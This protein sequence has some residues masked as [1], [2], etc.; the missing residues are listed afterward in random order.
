MASR[1][2]TY[3]VYHIANWKG[4]TQLCATLLGESL[5][6]HCISSSGWLYGQLWMNKA[7]VY[8]KP[9]ARFPSHWWFHSEVMPT[10][11]DPSVGD[12]SRCGHEKIIHIN[13]DAATWGYRSWV[14]ILPW[15]FMPTPDEYITPADS[16]VIPDQPRK[17]CWFSPLTTS[18]S[19]YIPHNPWITLVYP[20]W[21]KL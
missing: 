14:D 13:P 12:D 4:S 8:Q 21:T 11:N 5:L 7:P 16:L 17:S 15:V 9:R 6:S 3:H 2:K 10:R 19:C 1:G 18:I 20:Q